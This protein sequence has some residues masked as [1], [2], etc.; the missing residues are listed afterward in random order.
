MPGGQARSGVSEGG[1]PLG[2]GER[3]P[4]GNEGSFA[5]GEVSFLELQLYSMRHVQEHAAQLSL[6]LGQHGLPAPDW[7]SMARPDRE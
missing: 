4:G 1:I 2:E 5:W 3:D 6:Y 7:V